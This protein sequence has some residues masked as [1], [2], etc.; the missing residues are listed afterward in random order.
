MI[1]TS[2]AEINQ[3]MFEPKRSDQAQSTHR[4]AEST[5]PPS[6]DHLRQ[7]IDLLLASNATRRYSDDS[8]AAAA[9][10][11]WTVILVEEVSESAKSGLGP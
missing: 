3:L 5:F 1:H 9:G 4:L 11:G 2:Q 8:Q 10:S 6:Q 7:L